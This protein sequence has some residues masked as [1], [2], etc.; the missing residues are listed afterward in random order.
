MMIIHIQWCFEELSTIIYLQGLLI[1]KIWTFGN[2]WWVH[3]CRRSWSSKSEEKESVHRSIPMNCGNL[4]HFYAISQE[5]SESTQIKMLDFINYPSRASHELNALEMGKVFGASGA[6]DWN[7]IL[8]PKG[9]SVFPQICYP[10]MGII[11]IYGIL[12]PRLLGIS[13]QIVSNWISSHTQL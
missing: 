5:G 2:T 6:V 4:W 3:D 8:C 9:P 10:F 12:Y 1:A 7:Q 11:S 13:L